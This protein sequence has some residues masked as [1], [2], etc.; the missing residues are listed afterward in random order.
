M[1]NHDILNTIEAVK[2]PDVMT[3]VMK[4]ITA[5]PDVHAAAYGRETTMTQL[6]TKDEYNGDEYVG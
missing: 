5:R 4:E 1:N 3:A 6:V 2:L